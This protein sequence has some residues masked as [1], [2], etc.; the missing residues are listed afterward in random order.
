MV[1]NLVTCEEQSHVG[2]KYVYVKDLWKIFC[3]FICLCT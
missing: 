1:F 2:A 3:F